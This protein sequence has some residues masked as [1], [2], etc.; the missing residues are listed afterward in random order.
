MKNKSC[1]NNK[2]NSEFEKAYK[3]RMAS[4]F[5]KQTLEYSND[6]RPFTTGLELLDSK[7]NNGN[8]FELL[9]KSTLTIYIIIENEFKGIHLAPSQFNRMSMEVQSSSDF[10][11][12]L[13]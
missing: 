13:K 1:S 7:K 6:G 4:Y 2:L 5:D 8:T 9:H 12:K 10:K 11:D 3:S